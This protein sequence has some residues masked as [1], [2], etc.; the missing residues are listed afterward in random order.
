MI[1]TRRLDDGSRS[2]CG[3]I[4][5]VLRRLRSAHG[6]LVCG[7]NGGIGRLSLRVDTLGDGLAERLCHRGAAVVDRIPIDDEGSRI[8]EDA[9][10]GPEAIAE[11]GRDREME[12]LKLQPHPGERRRE[13][14]GQRRLRMVGGGDGV[15]CRGERVQ[16]AEDGLPVRVIGIAGCVDDDVAGGDD[17]GGALLP[18]L[19]DG[20]AFAGSV[21]IA[22]SRRVPGIDATGNGGG[23]AVRPESDD[24]SAGRAPSSC[25]Y[26]DPSDCRPPLTVTMPPRDGPPKSRRDGDSDKALGAIR[27]AS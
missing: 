2:G 18:A 1:R 4:A 13:G 22:R 12:G 21:A 16:G 23:R 11:G 15:G 10:H 14:I 20:A 24:D 25:R 7:K 6:R 26:P 3:I 9:G 8:A 19:E 5:S 27:P 17:G